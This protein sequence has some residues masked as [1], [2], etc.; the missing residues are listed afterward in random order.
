MKKNIEDYNYNCKKVIMRCDFNVP[1]NENK[2]IDNKRI[3]ESLKS[4]NYILNN[5]GSLILLSHLGKIK[6]ED[7]KKNNSL[8]IV[9][10]ELSKLLNKEVKFCPETRGDVLTEMVNGLK[11][12]EIILVENTRFEDLNN[13]AESN[14]DLDLAKYWASLGEIFINDAYGTCHRAHASNIGITKFLPSA[15]GYLVEKELTNI[16]NFINEDS[17]PFIVIM[18]GK[19]VSDKISIIKNLIMKC[20]KLLIG[21]GMAWTFLKANGL[22]VGSSITDDEKIDFCME[23]LNKYPTKIIL[24]IDAIIEDKENN[25]VNKDITNMI[26]TD[27]G[28]DIGPKTIELFKENLKNSKRV[29]MNGPLGVFENENYQ[30]GTISIYEYIKENKIKTLIGG[31]ETA[32]SAIKFGYENSFYHI[33]TGGG[34]TL[35]YL[36]GKVLPGIS[37]IN[38][39]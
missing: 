21:G 3:K 11:P 36:E 35:E 4:I 10:D 1:I 18:G 20:D 25:I 14:C 17:H 32:A 5:N 30:N 13:N 31:G 8:K 28:F 16:D 7:D 22:N 12:K 34:A 2:I 39:K 38:D 29:L 27:T 6:N 24:P 37:A 23:M 33:S 26:S 9:A 15:I 19:K